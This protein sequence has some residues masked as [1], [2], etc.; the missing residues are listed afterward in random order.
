MSFFSSLEL[1]TTLYPSINVNLTPA[2]KYI[3]VIIP[4]R[5][6]IK[7]QEVYIS[8]IRRLREQLEM[9]KA[10]A[11]ELQQKSEKLEFA[12]ATERE[13]LDEARGN[14]AALEKEAKKLK[15]QVRRNDA[16]K[17]AMASANDEKKGISEEEVAQLRSD[18]AEA[19]KAQNTLE[20]LLAKA[21]E[22]TDALEAELA[23]AE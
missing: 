14:F 19:L 7:S 12:V 3:A 21:E 13:R 23:E 10:A 17:L 4:G 16:E 18:L 8:D 22:R 1:R 20:H 15:E 6:T 2:I 5:Q 11:T 9:S